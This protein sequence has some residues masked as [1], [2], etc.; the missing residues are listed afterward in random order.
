MTWNDHS[1]THL[2]H[3]WAGGT[4]LRHWKKVPSFPAQWVFWITY[5]FSHKYKFTLCSSSPCAASVFVRESVSPR[6]TREGYRIKECLP[7]GTVVFLSEFF[8]RT[9]R[10]FTDSYL[11]RKLRIFLGT[12]NL[13][14]YTC[15]NGLEDLFSIKVTQETLCYSSSRTAIVFGHESVSPWGTREGYRVKE[16]LPVGTVVYLLVFFERPLLALVKS[17]DFIF[18]AF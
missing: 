1:S 18:V 8:E 3:R 7:E 17:I 9:L 6:G 4:F 11:H 5:E 16:G 15:C 2:R 10:L 13:T 14:K 12:I